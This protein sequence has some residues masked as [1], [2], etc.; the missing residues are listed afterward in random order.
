MILFKMWLKFPLRILEILML[1]FHPTTKSK[2]PSK[3]Q[4]F[5]FL[6][7]HYDGNQDSRKVLPIAKLRMGGMLQKPYKVSDE[8]TLLLAIA[9]SLRQWN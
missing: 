3:C 1:S 9:R 8:R 7:L 6:Q 4:G 2:S 5:K